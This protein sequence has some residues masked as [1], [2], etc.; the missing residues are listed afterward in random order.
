MNEVGG[1]I[2][3][4]REGSGDGCLRCKAGEGVEIS[5]REWTRDDRL[6][7]RVSAWGKEE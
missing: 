6:G 3:D 1:R 5:D 2:E 7:P 4:N